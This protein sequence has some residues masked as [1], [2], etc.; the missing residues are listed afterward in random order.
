MDSIAE[1]IQKAEK[2]LA[3]LQTLD[4]E[5]SAID[6]TCLLL[7]YL[8]KDSGASSADN[9]MI[10]MIHIHSRTHLCDVVVG[11]RVVEVERGKL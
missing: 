4:S 1:M 8:S 6:A 2:A 10:C 7:V 11:G 9:R 5:Q 3:Q